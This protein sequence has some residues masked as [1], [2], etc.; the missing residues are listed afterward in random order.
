MLFPS[1]YIVTYIQ[2]ATTSPVADK[3]L[4]VALVHTVHFLKL[5][6]TES[7]WNAADRYSSTKLYCMHVLIRTGGDIN[8]RQRQRDMQFI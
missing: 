6:A 3:M 5:K 8:W 2:E 7:E 1:Y 4:K